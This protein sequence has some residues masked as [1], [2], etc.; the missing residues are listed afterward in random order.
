[1]KSCTVKTAAKFTVYLNEDMVDLFRDVTFDFCGTK[2]TFTPELSEKLLETT[3]KER[4]DENFQFVSKFTFDTS[5]N[6]TVG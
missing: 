2:T 1:M 5:G 6:V 3:T 4:G